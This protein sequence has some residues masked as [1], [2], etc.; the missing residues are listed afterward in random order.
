[1]RMASMGRDL[2]CLPFRLPLNFSQSLFPFLET[3]FLYWVY[4]NTAIPEL[5]N[6]TGVSDEVASSLRCLF[7]HTN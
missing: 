1:M 2:T 3:E 7:S 6:G 4:R 5:V